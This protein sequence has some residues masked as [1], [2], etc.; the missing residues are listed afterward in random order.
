[1]NDESDSIRHLL[2]GIDGALDRAARA[3]A[4]A[5]ALAARA[6]DCRSW[7]LTAEAEQASAAGRSAHV[8]ALVARGDAAALR[9]RI[10]DPD[11]SMLG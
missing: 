7:G 11:G 3:E 10:A 6:G 9:L 8:A 5:D 1:M 2:H 4:E